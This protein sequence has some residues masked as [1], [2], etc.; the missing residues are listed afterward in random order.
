L[1]QKYEN[2]T[3]HDEVLKLHVKLVL[4]KIESPWSSH[5]P[6]PQYS[7]KSAWMH[8]HKTEEP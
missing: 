8:A 7:N 2:C 1:L 4:A 3:I 5:K 6:S